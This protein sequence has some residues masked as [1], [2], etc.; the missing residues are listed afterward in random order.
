VPRKNLAASATSD[1]ERKLAPLFASLAVDVQGRIAKGQS[2]DAAITAAAKAK[3]IERRVTNAIMDGVGDLVEDV[4]GVGVGPEFRKTWLNLHWPGEDLNLS[5]RINDITRMDEIRSSIKI[6]MRKAE[7]WA[8]M[9]LRLSE[10]NLQKADLA[11]HIKQ[12]YFSARGSMQGDPVALKAYRKDLVASMRQVDRLAQAG[13]PTR[14]LKAAYQTVIDV[15]KGASE[16]ALNKSMEILMREKMRYNADRIARTES[17]KGY[18]QAEY[19]TTLEDEQIIGMGY[20]LN[21]GHPRTDICDFHT[22]A[23][24]YN[25]GRG[26]YPLN[27]LPPFPF[28]VMCLCLMYKVY[29]GK[30]KPFNKKAA[31]KFIGD[32]PEKDRRHMLGIVGNKAFKESPSSW[33]QHLRNFEGHQSIQSLRRVKI[34]T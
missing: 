6:S 31:E 15:S 8:K 26:K 11:N 18:A 28:H 20:D 19:T 16:K 5:Q 25:M 7:S 24:L 13:A 2:V 12:L 21:V 30:A 23:N 10:Q 4:S 34:K 17:A 22:K 33:Q 3:N 1:I 27:K 29:A 14:A 32:L 9:S